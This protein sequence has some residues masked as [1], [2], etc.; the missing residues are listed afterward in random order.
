MNARP[1]EVAAAGA[2]RGKS[3][4][5]GAKPQQPVCEQA[6]RP[7]RRS[8]GGG[9]FFE[10]YPELVRVIPPNEIPSRT[11]PLTTIPPTLFRLMT[12]SADPVTKLQASEVKVATAARGTVQGSVSIPAISVTRAVP[13]QLAV[14]SALSAMNATQPISWLC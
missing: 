7:V 13:P 10:Q 9:T 11:N 8:A 12:P 1:G 6:G 4:G 2:R 14:T 5:A 3:S